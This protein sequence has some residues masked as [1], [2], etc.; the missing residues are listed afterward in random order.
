MVGCFHSGLSGTVPQQPL[1]GGLAAV[2]TVRSVT[3]ELDQ[4][5]AIQ[6]I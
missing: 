5:P 4:W 1:P 3:Q 2:L 6:S